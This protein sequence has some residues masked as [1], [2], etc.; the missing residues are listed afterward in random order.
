[1]QY[2]LQC[3]EI[4]AMLSDRELQKLWA[5]EAFE[6]NLRVIENK[7]GAR[8]DGRSTSI[9]GRINDLAGV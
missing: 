8:I 4:G 9:C 6:T 1:M 3:E 2:R 7:A 5:T